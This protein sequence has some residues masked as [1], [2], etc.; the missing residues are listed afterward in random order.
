MQLLLCLL[1][2][3]GIGNLLLLAMVLGKYLG[4]TGCL[5]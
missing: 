4:E 1:I 5:S 3:L 2:G